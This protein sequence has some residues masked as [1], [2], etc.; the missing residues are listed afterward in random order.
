MY[1]E[2]KNIYIELIFAGTIPREPEQN[3]FTG[4]N[5]L[6]A[7]AAARFVYVIGAQ[8]YSDGFTEKWIE[9]I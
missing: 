5:D 9:K 4:E 1:Y 2:G 3:Y 7:A 8:R 6:Y